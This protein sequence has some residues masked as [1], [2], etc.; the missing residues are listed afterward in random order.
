MSKK[1]R[2]FKDGDE[3]VAVGSPA[4]IRRV[5]RNL[6]SDGLYHLRRDHPVMREGRTY[7]VAWP[8]DCCAGNRTYSV[9]RYRG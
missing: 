8:V 2:M 6:E 9:G 4:D 5:I 1:F 3:F 7:T